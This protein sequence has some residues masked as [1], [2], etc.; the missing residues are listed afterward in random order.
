MSAFWDALAGLGI[1]AL[2]VLVTVALTVL[3]IKV[4]TRKPKHTDPA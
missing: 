3:A 2:Q 1:M 4:M